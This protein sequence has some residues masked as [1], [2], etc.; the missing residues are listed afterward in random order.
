[1]KFFIKKA[2]LPFRDLDNN[3]RVKW[4]VYV[5]KVGDEKCIEV[6]SF[7]NDYLGA[8]K[9]LTRCR[10]QYEE[11]K[12]LWKTWIISNKPSERLISSL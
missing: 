1:M 9:Y 5:Y 6:Q 2:I 8:K 4:A 11:K 3:H 7:I 10:E 12:D